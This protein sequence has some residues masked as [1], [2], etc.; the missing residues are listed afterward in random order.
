MSKANKYQYNKIVAVIV[1]ARNEE[2][3]L[4][5]TLSALSKLVPPSDLYIVDDGSTDKTAEIAKKYSKKVLSIK[6]QGK[7]N[8]LNKCIKHY[9]LTRRYEYILFMDADTRPNEDFLKI[10]MK[11]FNH[12]TKKKIACV[13][14]RI[15]SYGVSYISKYRQWE[16]QISHF[17]HKQAQWYMSSILV[18]PGCATVFRS[19]V[20]NKIT[21]S[22][23]TLTEDMDFTFLMHRKRIGKMVF[24]KNAIVYTQDPEKIL[25]FIKQISRWYTGFWQ[26]VR[27]HGIPWQGQIIDLEAGLLALEGLYNGIFVILLM[28]SIIPLALKGEAKILAIPLLI[29]LFVFFIPTLTWNSISEKDFSRIL[30]IPHFYLLRFLS[31]II[32]LKSFFDGYLIREKQFSWQSTRYKFA[33]SGV[34]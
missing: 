28:T 3:V 20:F 11:H 29:D 23:G 33:E 16:Y 34:N 9:G 5:D 13:V 18:V 21:F 10:A 17:V 8:A 25:H 12:D 2:S 14:G 30:Y 6:N 22:N 27:K 26:V 4:G 31:S 7:A 15:K 19:S 24:E 32:F 1:P